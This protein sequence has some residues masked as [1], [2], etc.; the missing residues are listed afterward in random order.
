MSDD[1]CKHCDERWEN[2]ETIDGYRRCIFSFRA[3]EVSRLPD[4]ERIAGLIADALQKAMHNDWRYVQV[5]VAARVL[6][7]EGVA[8]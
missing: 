7:E 1:I 6:R 4:A 2:H 3:K 5:A 8:E